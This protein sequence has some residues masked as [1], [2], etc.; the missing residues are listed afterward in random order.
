MDWISGRVGGRD[1]I[2]IVFL[3]AMALGLDGADLG[4]VGAM[5]SILQTRFSISKIEIGLLISVSKGIG[6]FSALFFGGFVDRTCRTRL[7]A[8]I[9]GL[10]AV[11]IIACGA[12]PS[13]MFLLGARMVLGA[14]AAATLPCTASLIGDYFPGRDWGRIYGYILSG[15]MIGTG[16]GFIVSGEMAHF[17]WRLGFWILAI[18]SIPLAWFIYQL[19][20]PERGGQRR[21]AAKNGEDDERLIGKKAK[22][23][24]VEPRKR[25]VRNDDPATK[26]IWW[27]IKY[28][29]SIPTNA[30]LIISSAL[31][32]AF[33][34]DVRTF[35]VEYAQHGYGLSRTAAV[36][37]LA[38][39]GIGA[40]A[41]VWVGGTLGDRLLA[42]GHLP[43]RVWVATAFFCA[44]VVLFF[45]GFFFAILWLSM[46]L[47]VCSSF[48]LGAVNPP[49]DSARLDIIHP[50]LWGRAESVRMVLRNATEAAAPV[51][52]GWLVSDF[53]GGATGL[54]NGFFIML[55]P[56]AIAGGIAFITFRTYPADAAAATAYRK[57][58]INGAG[59]D[60]ERENPSEKE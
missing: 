51:T 9:V 7:L 49:L 59:S 36:G 54:R 37:M 26:S 11:A 33:F 17:W 57:N 4:T 2:W 6:I 35:G 50:R 58:T 46:I 52:F 41:G 1:R 23:A 45:F 21:R 56:L 38:I 55:I 5:S 28:V 60:D 18:P 53:G 3:L 16:F 24:Q 27:A 43:A 12:A 30:V 48:S 10:W 40:I 31:G 47:F 32:Y 29:L 34:S 19:R 39:L 14:L 25:L 15:E 20:E 44:S 42:K 22:E 8:I 13:F